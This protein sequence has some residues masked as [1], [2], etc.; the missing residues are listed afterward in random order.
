MTITRHLGFLA[1]CCS[2]SACG[3]EEGA[4]QEANDDIVEDDVVT[5]P[6]VALYGYS[7]W[8]RVYSTSTSFVDIR[9][10]KTST[11]VN[12]EF[13][14]NPYAY[15]ITGGTSISTITSNIAGISSGSKYRTHNQSSRMFWNFAVA[16]SQGPLTVT[17]WG[18]AL[19]AIPAC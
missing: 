12:W 8:K 13:R 16:T 19:S 10:C 5:A 1:L 2:L 11:R 7:G 3:L 4:D 15:V 9:Y 6:D 17:G 18:E 14:N